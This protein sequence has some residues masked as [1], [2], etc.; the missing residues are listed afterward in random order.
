MFKNTQFLAEERVT[1]K[2]VTKT[3]LRVIRLAR[4]SNMAA[5]QYAQELMTKFFSSKDVYKNRTS[6]SNSFENLLVSVIYNMREYCGRNHEAGFFDHSFHATTLFRLQGHGF[7]SIRISLKELKSRHRCKKP[8]S[9]RKA[10]VSAI[11]WKSVVEIYYVWRRIV[12]TIVWGQPVLAEWTKI[13]DCDGNV[14]R[15]WSAI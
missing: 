10:G 12:T 7:A 8:W 9:T 4:P 6:S 14:G 3:E 11:M 13:I 2:V 15:D 5:P 1:H